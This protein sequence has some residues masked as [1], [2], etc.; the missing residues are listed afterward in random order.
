MLSDQ[1]FKSF[2]ALLKLKQEGKY[3]KKVRLPKYLDKKKGR[4]TAFYEKGAISL[5]KDGYVK[6]SQTGIEIK[7]KIS[8]NR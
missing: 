4:I 6:L 2:F 7:T 8:R 5:K 1:S 3:N